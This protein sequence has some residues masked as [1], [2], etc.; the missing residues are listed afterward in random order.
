MAE[1]GLAR[2]AADYGIT[3]GLEVVN[4]YLT[5]ILN[6]AQQVRHAPASTP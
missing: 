3:Y 6:T 4:R 1:Q 5:N 2:E